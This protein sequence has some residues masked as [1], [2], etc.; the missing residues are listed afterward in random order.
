MKTRRISIREAQPNMVT[1]EDIYTYN[2]QLVIGKGTVLTDVVI[3]KLKFYSISHFNIFIAD[4]TFKSHTIKKEVTPLT[5]IKESPEFKQFSKSFVTSVKEFKGNLKNVIT[6]DEPLDTDNLLE[7]TTKILADAR[8]G[9]HV[10][11]MLHNLRSYDDLTYVHS[12]NVSLIARVFG[13]WLKLSEEDIDVLTVAG[14]LHDIGKL[15]LPASIMNKKETLTED[16]YELMKSHASRGFKILQE[17]DIDPR[18]KYATL[19][20]HERNDG[21]GYPQGLKADEIHTFAKII[22]IADVYDAMTSARVYRNA[23]CPFDA[24]S[25]FEKEGYQKFDAKFLLVFLENICQ[26][27]IGHQVRLSNG[28][29]GEIVMLNKQALSRPMIKSGKEF[30]DLSAHSDLTIDMIL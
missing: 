1:A 14:L 23:L 3:T 2:N 25:M 6:T 7:H 12:V 22:A 10:F 15:T 8:N 11:N 17:K 18:I 30:I 26:S 28:V 13:G 27:Y 20:H 5:K 9:L 19:M 4:E 16:E 24:I 21:S 29:K